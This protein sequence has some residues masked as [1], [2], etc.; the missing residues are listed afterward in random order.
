MDHIC[1]LKEELT[2]DLSAASSTNHSDLMNKSCTLASVRTDKK[3]D[4]NNDYYNCA[5]KWIKSWT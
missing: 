2:I 1:K 3:D 5:N 4:S